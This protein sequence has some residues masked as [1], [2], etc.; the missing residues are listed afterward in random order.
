M[1]TK[2]WELRKAKKAAMTEEELAAEREKNRLR[3]QVRRENL[4]PAQREAVRE[5]DRIRNRKRTERLRAERPEKIR[6]SPEERALRNQRAK[7]IAKQPRKGKLTE[8]QKQA[9]KQVRRMNEKETKTTRAIN[10]FIAQGEPIRGYSA[11]LQSREAIIAAQM[12]R[13]TL[14]DR[15]AS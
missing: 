7:A 4:T 12:S 15:E 9:R 10:E 1:A 14:E 3:A 5:K 8:E 13:P 2:S 11:F 6:A